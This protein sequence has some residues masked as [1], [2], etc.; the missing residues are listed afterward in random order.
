MYEIKVICKKINHSIPN[1]Y[2]NRL[3]GYISS[4]L[5][6]EKYGKMG[7]DYTYSNILGGFWTKDGLC[8]DKDVPHFLIRTNNEVVLQNF[9]NNLKEH[10]EMFEGLVVEKF[11]FRKLDLNQSRFRTLSVSPIIL[12]RYGNT[13]RY[14][15]KNELEISE[16]TLVENIRQKGKEENFNVD[17]NLSIKILREQKQ[18]T[19]GYRTLKKGC[20]GNEYITLYH[21]GRVFDLDIN[22]NSA[23]KEFILTHG[24]GNASSIGCGYII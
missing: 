10:R 11:S 9:L 3:H 5:G 6:N 21:R 19:I 1:F 4:L 22:C 13:N 14:L 24:L 17:D 16:K 23:T 18:V 20:G 15:N 8:F 2:Y 12:K 7:N